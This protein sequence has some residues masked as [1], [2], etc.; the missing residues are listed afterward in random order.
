MFQIFLQWKMIGSNSICIYF[1][2]IVCCRRD[3]HLYRVLL[4]NKTLT[5]CLLE[6][7]VFYENFDP[8]P[9]LAPSPNSLLSP[10][11]GWGE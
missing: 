5:V 10:P 1:M 11:S 9:S 7:G 6:M 4:R 8:L 3:P 2:A